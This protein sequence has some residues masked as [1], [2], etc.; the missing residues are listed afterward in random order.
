MTVSVVEDKQNAIKERHLKHIAEISKDLAPLK[1]ANLTQDQQ[2]FLNRFGPYAPYR[3]ERPKPE[4]EL[5]EED[6]EQW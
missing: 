3:P 5:E 2:D 1:F 4:T 6:E